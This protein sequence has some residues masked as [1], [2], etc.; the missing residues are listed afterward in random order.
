MSVASIRSQATRLVSGIV[1]FGLALACS[2]TP[3]KRA[4][5]KPQL[6]FHDE[7]A[8]APEWIRRGC[9]AYWADAPDRGV[10]GVGS[11]SGSRNMAL[12]TSTAEGRGRTAIARSLSTKVRTMLKDYQATTTGGAEF[13]TAAA[14]E[15]HIVD[16]GKQL[17]NGSL[18]G[19]ERRDLWISPSGVV[20][21][22]MVLDLEKFQGAVWSMKHLSESLRRRVAQEAA[23]EFGGGPMETPDSTVAAAPGAPLVPPTPAT[24]QS[25]RN[26]VSER[27]A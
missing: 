4:P 7:L 23:R 27:A 5:R 18:T 9:S 6:G 22:L 12:T 17:T 19:A 20:Y 1:V 25:D 24:Q 10:C 14:D 15:Q 26:L 11:T 2:S 13:G 8:G 3:E 21:A 16:V